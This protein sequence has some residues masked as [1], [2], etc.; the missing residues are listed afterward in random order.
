MLK[1]TLGDTQEVKE[2]LQKELSSQKEQII[3]LK[4][5]L[6]L[7]TEQQAVLKDKFRA[8]KQKSEEMASQLLN[9]TRDKDQVTMEANKIQSEL[10]GVKNR[11]TQYERELEQLKNKNELMQKD[12]YELSETCRSNEDKL[13]NIISENDA[14]RQKADTLESELESEVSRRNFDT[15]H[16]AEQNDFKVRAFES[17]ITN[18]CAYIKSASYRLRNISSDSPSMISDGFVGVL[19]RWME[20]PSDPLPLIEQWVQ[21]VADE[22]ET[23]SGRSVELKVEA[24]N[25]SQIIEKLTSGEIEHRE[26]EKILR[27]Q[28]ESIQGSV[29]NSPK[30]EH[31]FMQSQNN[32]NLPL[33]IGSPS[34]GQTQLVPVQ[35]LTQIRTFEE[36]IDLLLTEKESLEKLNRKICEILPNTELKAVVGDM[37]RTENEL[38]ELERNQI[39]IRGMLMQSET[40]M[41]LQARQSGMNNDG[42]SIALRREVENLR[43]FLDNNEQ[44]IEVNRKKLGTLEDELPIFQNFTCECDIQKQFPQMLAKEAAELDSPLSI[45]EG[46]ILDELDTPER[47]PLRDSATEDRPVP[48]GYY[49]NLKKIKSSIDGI[50]RKSDI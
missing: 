5:K 34:K 38:E 19:S 22:V 8:S 26:R 40:E 47:R 30:K 4:E 41:R 37:L 6:D 29:K 16:A 27:A 28:L 45:K 33:K 14:L 11:K 24:K 48:S 43:A 46:R 50:T 3:E 23:L 2:T 39:R 7:A 20:M 21:A 25:S 36:K 18:L 42:K 10:N 17:Y 1:Q 9:T 32:E 31:V 44:Q 35:D 15:A 13:Y 12:Y 49:E